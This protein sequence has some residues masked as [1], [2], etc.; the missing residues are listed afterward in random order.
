MTATTP[1]PFRV[2][3]VAESALLKSFD[4]LAPAEAYA[5]AANMRAEALGIDA[6]YQAIATPATEAT[7]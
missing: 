5:D 3:T 2:V 4:A 7:A 6:R 1:Q